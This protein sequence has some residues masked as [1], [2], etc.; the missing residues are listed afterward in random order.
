[1][2]AAFAGDPWS[3][4]F[5]GLSR[6]GVYELARAQLRTPFMSNCA[7]RTAV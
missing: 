1:M 7:T 5:G 2:R 4:Q 6:F 3:V